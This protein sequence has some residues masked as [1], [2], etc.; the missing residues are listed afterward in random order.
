MT[1]HNVETPRRAT[2]NGGPRIWSTRAILQQGLDHGVV[3]LRGGDVQGRHA[4]PVAGVNDA[5]RLSGHN[6]RGMQLS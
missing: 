5:R 4:S 2:R 6:A 1:N 3:A